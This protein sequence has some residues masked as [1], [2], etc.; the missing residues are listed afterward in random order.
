VF[1]DAVFQAVVGLHGG[2]MRGPAQAGKQ[3]HGSRLFSAAGKD[4][5][6]A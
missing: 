6:A 1:P 3:A 2:A 4:A 5:I